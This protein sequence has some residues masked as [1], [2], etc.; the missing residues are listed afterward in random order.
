MILCF[1]F[2]LY[3]FR[4]CKYYITYMYSYVWFVGD[5]HN[6][7]LVAL[8]IIDRLLFP[9]SYIRGQSRMKYRKIA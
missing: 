6:Y 2:N 8:S 7:L 3:D 5:F 9:G 4:Y 1:A